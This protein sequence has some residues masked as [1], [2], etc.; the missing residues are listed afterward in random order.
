[1]TFPIFNVLLLE[2]FPV[3]SSSKN[4]PH[5]EAMSAQSNE[6][7]K[8]D[9]DYV[10]AAARI[11]AGNNPTP[12]QIQGHVDRLLN[13]YIPEDTAAKLEEEAKRFGD[14]SANPL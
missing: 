4:S 1:L 11:L 6:L 14:L 12:E 7:R 2:V 5:E 13:L 3:E 8:V 10:K 9:S